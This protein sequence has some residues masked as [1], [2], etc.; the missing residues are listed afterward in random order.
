MAAL[1]TN[2]FRTRRVVSVQFCESC[3][4]VC[5]SA[6]RAAAVYDRARTSGA[7]HALGV[8]FGPRS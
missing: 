2:L 8:P 4:S 3:S 5:N 1:I 6:C 7:A